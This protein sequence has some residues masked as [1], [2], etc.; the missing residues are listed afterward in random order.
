MKKTLDLFGSFFDPQDSRLDKLGDPPGPV[1]GG[2]GL[3][4]IP[5]VAGAYSAR[6]A[7]EQCRRPASGRG[8]DVQGIGGTALVRVER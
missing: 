7:Q 2:G 1:G 6:R 5:L 4:G 8:A 3:G